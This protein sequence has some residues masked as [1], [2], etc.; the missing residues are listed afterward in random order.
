VPKHSSITEILLKS[1]D[2]FKQEE[3]VINLC[4]L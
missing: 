1:Q 3:C 4:T 2:I